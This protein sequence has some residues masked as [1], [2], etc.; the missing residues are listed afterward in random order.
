MTDTTAEP[1]Y[2]QIAEAAF[3]D[4]LLAELPEYV[5]RI[6]AIRALFTQE[7]ERCTC[8][9]PVAEP[10]RDALVGGQTPTCEQIEAL[11]QLACDGSGHCRSPLHVH[12]CY[13]DDGNCEE[14]REHALLSQPSPSVGPPRVEDLAPGTTLVACLDGSYSDTRPFVY[15]AV[16]LSGGKRLVG[17]DGQIWSADQFEP[18]T[19]RNV[20]PP[21]HEGV[22]G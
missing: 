14:P 7:V 10:P 20:T 22:R 16:L 9:G 15:M 21:S 6:D 19:I 1:T 18:L 12:G 4:A 8:V 2:E 5:E 11:R 13:A 17:A 3:G